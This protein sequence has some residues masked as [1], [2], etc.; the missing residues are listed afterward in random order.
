MQLC[1]LCDAVHSFTI[2]GNT[3]RPDPRHHGPAIGL[4]SGEPQCV[5][6]VAAER[7]GAKTRAKGDVDLPAFIRM[8]ESGCRRTQQMH[9][10]S[11]YLAVTL[12]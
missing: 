1:A 12:V 3:V 5:G 7:R 10:L 8:P 6:E 4:P 11:N 9:R 2:G